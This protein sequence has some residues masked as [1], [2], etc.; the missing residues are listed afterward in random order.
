[1]SRQRNEQRILITQAMPNMVLAR[2]VQLPNKISLCKPGQILSDQL[3]LK[4]MNRGIKRIYVQGQ[5]LP[6]HSQDDYEERIRQLR[7]RFSRV[8][9]QIIM[10]SLERLVENE[11]VRRV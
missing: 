6:A 10:L 9:H 5:P 8:R 3:I 1:M 2:A 7:K 4:L 11:M